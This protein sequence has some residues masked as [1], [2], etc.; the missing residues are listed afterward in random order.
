[1][2]PPFRGEA[3]STSSIAVRSPCTS[4]ERNLKGDVSVYMVTTGQARA[5]ILYTND[6]N[7]GDQP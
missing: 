1:M 7:K 5:V 3:A 2:V 4:E 6:D